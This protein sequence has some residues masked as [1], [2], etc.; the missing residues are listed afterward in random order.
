MLISQD[1]NYKIYVAFS[2][3]ITV[4]TTFC[5]KMNNR[6]TST[7]KVTAKELVGIQ[8]R[9]EITLL[10]FVLDLCMIQVDEMLMLQGIHF[11]SGQEEIC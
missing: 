5:E 10:F 7:V 3:Y 2:K 6:S 11:R 4:E 1:E 8:L 9:V